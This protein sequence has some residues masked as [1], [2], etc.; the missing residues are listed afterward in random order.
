MGSWMLGLDVTYIDD[1]RFCCDSIRQGKR[2]T[3]L[4]FDSN[5]IFSFSRCDYSGPKIFISYII[6]SEKVC[7]LA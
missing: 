1:N 4:I 6:F 5:L 7:S 2:L 3:W